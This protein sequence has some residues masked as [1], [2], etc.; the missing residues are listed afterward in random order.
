MEQIITLFDNFTFDLITVGT[1]FIIVMILCALF[2]WIPKRT[3]EWFGIT[4][5]ELKNKNSTV[6][7]K[8]L[9]QALSNSGLKPEQAFFK[10]PHTSYVIR[11]S[12]GKRILI[13]GAVWD[14]SPTARYWVALE[15]MRASCHAE[16][17]WAIQPGMDGTWTQWLETGDLKQLKLKTLSQL[18]CWVNVEYQHNHREGQLT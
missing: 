15:E 11:D 12:K 8:S 9:G 14:K 13:D 16:E 4:V 7:S 18:V 10:L 17:A 6:F 3:K 2:L 1:F 5:Y